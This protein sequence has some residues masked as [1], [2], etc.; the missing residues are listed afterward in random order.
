MIGWRKYIE[1]TI[2]YEYGKLEL[3]EQ[4][5]ELFRHGF[6]HIARLEKCRKMPVVEGF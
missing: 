6:S 1:T 2:T 5:V 3:H 4:L